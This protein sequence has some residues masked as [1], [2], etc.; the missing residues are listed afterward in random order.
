M[1]RRWMP[2]EE[3][4]LTLLQCLEALGPVTDRQL[5]TF[6][7]RS[8]LIGYFDFALNLGSLTDR[9]Q[10]SRE[11]HPA[12][13]LLRLT[14]AG[15]RVLEAYR[16]RI[17]SSRRQ[18]I[19]DAS[20]PAREAFARSLQTPCRIDG[21]TAALTLTDREGAAAV[22][23]LTLPETA[24]PEEVRLRWEASAPRL[25]RRITEALY[26][27]GTVPGERGEALLRDGWLTLAA[28]REGGLSLRLRTD[29]EAEARRSAARWPECR[30]D[31]ERDILRCLTGEEETDGDE[32]D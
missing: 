18:I 15:R 32:A 31:L 4:R 29:D 12:G 22:L 10:V 27:D 3:C 21:R 7:L 17:P 28:S 14:D 6:V 9:G 2:E 30:E 24:R 20:A 1:E 5:E 25:W 26:G 13:I 11:E 19:A 16:G 8:D 23:T